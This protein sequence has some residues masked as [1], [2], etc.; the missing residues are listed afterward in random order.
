M[1]TQTP[2]ITISVIPAQAG[3][4]TSPNPDPQVSKFLNPTNPVNLVNPV[5]IL[6]VKIISNQCQ[7]V[8]KKSS[9]LRLSSDFLLLT[10]YS[11]HAQNLSKV[12]HFLTK[13]TQNLPKTAKIPPLFD[14]NMQKS[15]VFTSIW[16]CQWQDR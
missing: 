6:T 14:R 13:V 4:Q 12:V 8:S 11:K 15:S 16:A 10:S 1:K 3:T 7:S 2:N 5:K 9:L